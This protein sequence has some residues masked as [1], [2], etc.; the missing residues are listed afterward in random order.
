MNS[1]NYKIIKVISPNNLRKHNMYPK[2]TPQKN[3]D[4]DDF[5]G[6]FKAKNKINCVKLKHE[7]KNGGA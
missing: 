1:F 4:L 6:K 5:V 7:F 2:A 3:I